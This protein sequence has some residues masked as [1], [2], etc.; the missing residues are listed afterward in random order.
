LF[1]THAANHPQKWY[2]KLFA[3]DDGYKL[4][5][6]HPE[7]LF[8]LSN[9]APET[10][11]DTL[12]KKDGV[13]HIL[14]NDIRLPVEPYATDEMRTKFV[15]RMKRDGFEA[16][17]QW[18]RSM[19]LGEQDIANKSVPEANIVINVPT[20]FF[21]GTRDMVCRPELLGPSVEAGLLP[22]LKTVTVDAGHWALHAKPKEFGDALMEWLKENF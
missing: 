6:A 11:L 19:A 12:C 22:Q 13:K 3:A 9:A 14:E 1:C 4:L 7:A 8:D 10:W 2:W 18:Y 5:D 16:P 15:A 20:L 21:G 17:Q